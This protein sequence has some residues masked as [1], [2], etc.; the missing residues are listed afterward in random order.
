MCPACGKHYERPAL[1]H[2]RIKLERWR[3]ITAALWLTQTYGDFTRAEIAKHLT[4]SNSPELRGLLDVQ[5]LAV[6]TWT[7]DIRPHPQNGR[8]TYFHKCLPTGQTTRP[9]V[10]PRAFSTPGAAR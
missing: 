5:A 7:V 6:R 9:E 8:P 10:K 1:S 2:A 3:I 4:V